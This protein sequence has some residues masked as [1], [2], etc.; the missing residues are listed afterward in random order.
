MSIA[1]GFLQLGNLTHD[2][3]QEVVQLFA[4]ARNAVSLPVAM[5]E[6]ALRLNDFEDSNREGNQST[7]AIGSEVVVSIQVATNWRE[8]GSAEVRT[9]DSIQNACKITLPSKGKFLQST[10]G[11]LL[12]SC[13]SAAK[14][15]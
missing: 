5:C 13:A 2:V 7:E 14:S 1:T 11:K 6:T 15:A 4:A 10:L 12:C 8:I 9:V 3:D